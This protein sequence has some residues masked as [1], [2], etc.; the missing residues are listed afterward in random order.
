MLLAVGN[1][2]LPSIHQNVQ[3]D[4]SQRPQNDPSKT[5]VRRKRKIVSLL[6]GDTFS[7]VYNNISGLNPKATIGEL[8]R[9]MDSYSTDLVALVKPNPL[10][11][12]PIEPTFFKGF[13]K[14]SCPQTKK[15][16]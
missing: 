13:H 5:L 14:Y 10:V 9:F 15:S 2:L 16:Q 11:P 1:L 12:H 8:E 6:K 4:F 7:L 3:A